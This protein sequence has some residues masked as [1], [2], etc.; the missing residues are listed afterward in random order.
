MSTQEAR[1]FEDYHVGDVYDVG[2]I[3][4]SEAEMIDFAK[5]YDPQ[6]FHIDPAKAAA[7]P[8]GGLIASGWQTAA[9][10]MRPLV[11]SFLHSASSLGS[12][13]IDELRWL[14]SVRPGDMLSVRAT[15]VDARRS[16]SKPDRGILRT[17]IEVA[18]QDSVLVMTL[19][20]VNMVTCR[21]LAEP[22]SVS[23]N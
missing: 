17:H 8:Y 13:G 20:A 7:G 19:N 16:K 3:S 11:D 12:P 1:Y 22:E 21:N 2:T 5:K 9:A 23:S 10:V 4:M 6:D 18:N 15:V 14:A